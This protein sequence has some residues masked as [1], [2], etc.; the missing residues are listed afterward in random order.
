MDLSTLQPKHAL[1]AKKPRVGRGGKRGTMS[2]KGQKGQKSRAGR[3]IRPA[4]RDLIQRLHKLR[5]VKNKPREVG[6]PVLN[7]QD[8]AGLAKDGVVSEK[9][10]GRKVKIL[11]DGE[12]GTPVIVEGLATSRSAK[13]KIE[14]A[15][16]KVVEV[17]KVVARIK[18][19]EKAK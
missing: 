19:A 11:G 18:V 1:K 6:L 15:G 9:V 16:G 17:V 8:L 2:G 5:G 10:L 14:K 3:R 7:V 13:E 4:Q 12:I